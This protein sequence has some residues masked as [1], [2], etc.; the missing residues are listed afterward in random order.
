MPCTST[1]IAFLD[2]FHRDEIH[3]VCQ[4]KPAL[5][6]FVMCVASVTVA[7]C[8]LSDNTCTGGLGRQPASSLPGWLSS[9]GGYCEKKTSLAF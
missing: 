1:S 5:M 3:F 9:Q 4:G 7:Y 2:A 8:T 6:H